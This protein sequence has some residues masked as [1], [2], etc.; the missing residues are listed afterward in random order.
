[1]AQAIMQS[2]NMQSF[3]VLSCHSQSVCGTIIFVDK[4]IFVD[5]AFTYKGL[6][7]LTDDGFYPHEP[8][9]CDTF[10]LYHY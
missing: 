1:M 7:I 6:S 5:R 10:A 8:H 4:G 9:S 2:R 3:D